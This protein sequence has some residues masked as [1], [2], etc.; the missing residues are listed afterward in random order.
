FLFL[1]A[2]FNLTTVRALPP[3]SA[4]TITT[5]PPAKDDLY[6]NLKVYEPYVKWVSS[7]STNT[8]NMA[9]ESSSLNN[10][11]NSSNEA[12]NTAFEVTTAGTQ[13]N[14]ANST[15]IDNL[16]D[17]IICAVLESQSN[18]SQLMA[19]LTMRAKRFLKNTG[20]KLNLNRNGTITFDK[21]KVECYNCHNRGHFARE[22]RAPRAQDNKNIESTRRNVL[23]KLLTPQLWCLVMDLENASKS[24]NKLIDSQIVDNCK[25]GLGYNVVP[26]P[27]TGLFMP[28]KPDLSYI[29]LEEFI[30]EPTVETLNAKTSEEVPKVVKKDNGVPIIEDWKSNAED[31]SG[32]PQMDLQEKG[33]IDSGCSRHMTGNMSYLTDYEEIDG[34]CVAFRGNPKGG[35]SLAKATSDESRLWHRRLGHL[36]FKTMNKLV[37]GNLVRE[38]VSTAC[39]VQNRVL[40]VKPYNKTPYILFYGRTPMLSFMRPFGCLVTILNT[41]DHLGKF[42]GKADEGFFVGYSLNSKAFRAFNS[43][44]RIVEE[45]LHTRFSENTPNNIEPKE[46]T[47]T[48]TYSSQ[49]PQVQDK[50]KGK[51]KLIEEP[52]MPKKRKHQIRVDEKLAEKLQ[53][54]MQAETDEEDRLARERESSKPKELNKEEKAKLFMELLEKRRKFFAAKRAKEKINR[55]PTK[56]QERSIVSTYLKNMDGWKI[57]SLKNKSFAEIQKPF[58]K[59]MKRLRKYGKLAK[60]Y[61]KV[62]HSTFKMSR[63]TYFGS[64]ENSP[65]TMEKQWNLITQEW[66]RFVMIVKQQHKLDEVSYHKLFD[67]LKQYQKEV[68][69]LRAERIAM[70]ANPLALVSIAQSNQDPYYQTLKPYKPYTPT[71]IP[72][73]SHATTRN[74]GKKIYKPTN[75]NLRTSSNSRNKNVDTTPRYKNDNQSGQFRSQRTVNVARAKENVGS[76]ILQQIGIQCFNC[77]KFGY[78][79]KECRKPKR[80]RDSAYYKENMFLCK[81]A[82]KGVPLQSEQSD[83]LADTNEEI[84]EQE[85]KAHYSYMVKIQEVPT[86]DSCTNFEPLE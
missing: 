1:W 7:S 27:Y 10:N 21:T 20:W 52:K 42:N 61:N 23:L 45:T 19:M 11:T 86:A 40:V 66:S 56:A 3:L 50:G 53:A 85:L 75:N 72:T 64:L 80:V 12:V 68:N 81:Q 32:N 70:N 84:D 31:E 43:R 47:T 33:V 49:Q 14:A 5:V 69:E 54:E 44:T 73:R 22:C 6:N 29:G 39:Y 9:F 57:K 65:L 63:Q 46:T 15:N 25:K 48:K 4:T 71:S 77:K 82:E 28:P 51:A 67:I 35:K 36:N 13:V 74:K 58:D 34:G 2:V 18:S 26:P 62:N 17:A 41:I 8:Q 78:F 30:S 24:L 79:A 76:S 83:W 59:A 37:K 16:S 60:G 38:A 55:P